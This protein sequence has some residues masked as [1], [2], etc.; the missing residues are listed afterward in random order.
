VKHLGGFEAE[1]SNPV[2]DTLARTE[3]DR[4]DVEGELVDHS[5]DQCLSDGRG[6]TGDVDALVPGGLARCGV[7]RV[8][9]LGDEIED[10]P[11]VHLDRVMSVM[12]QHEH[13]RVIRRFGAPPA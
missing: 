4:C 8:E 3:Q 5:G 13:R 2:E 9:A 7:G 6:P 1:G 11:A 12:G 10:R